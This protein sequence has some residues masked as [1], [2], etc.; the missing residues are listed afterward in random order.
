MINTEELQRLIHRAEDWMAGKSTEQK[1]LMAIQIMLTTN[2]VELA[3]FQISQ[4]REKTEV[5]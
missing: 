1:D 5:S 2:A 4:L 3:V